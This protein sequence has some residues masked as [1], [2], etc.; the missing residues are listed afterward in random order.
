[1]RQSG[2]NSFIPRDMDPSNLTHSLMYR[3]G[4]PLEAVNLTEIF[5]FCF[6]NVRLLRSCLKLIRKW[7]FHL[8]L[9]NL[10]HLYQVL[11]KDR[12]YDYFL[13]NYVGWLQMLHTPVHKQLSILNYNLYRYYLAHLL[14]S[15]EFRFPYC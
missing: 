15:Q 12:Y 7:S 14:K 6:N 9:N 4:L 13:S 1:M 8:F 2:S 10:F 5:R 3:S 11:F